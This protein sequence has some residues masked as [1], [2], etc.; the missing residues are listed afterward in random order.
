MHLPITKL[1]LNVFT[2]ASQSAIYP[3]G[4]YH[5]PWLKEITCSVPGSIFQKFVSPQQIR[6]EWGGTMQTIIKFT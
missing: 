3:P 1:T 6:H 5:Y 2:C 4:S